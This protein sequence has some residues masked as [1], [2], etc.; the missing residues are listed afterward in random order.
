MCLEVT[1]NMASSRDNE[2][3]PIRVRQANL[4]VCREIRYIKWNQ[5]IKSFESQTKV[6]RLH[7][8]HYGALYIERAQYIQGEW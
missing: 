7:N 5:H 6:F 4:W 3:S 2:I 1:V 8:V